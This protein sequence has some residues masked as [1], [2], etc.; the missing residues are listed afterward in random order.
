MKKV[1]AVYFSGTGTTKRTVNFI[2]SN[3][4]EKLCL[5]KE[6]FNFT[7]PKIR[8][9]IKEFDK[10]DFVIFGVPVIA[11][12]VPNVLLKYFEKLKGNG[13]MVVPIVLFGNRNFNDSLLELSDLLINSNFKPISAGAFIGEH[14]FSKILAKGRPDEKDFNIM[15][16]FSEKI[17]EKISKKDFDP[18]KFVE[19]THGERPFK[20]YKP[21]DAEGNYIDIRKVIP[22]T[23]SSLCDDCKV[24][25]AVC[26]MGSIDYND[27]EKITGICIKCCACIKKCH[28][29]A[30]Y[31]ADKGYLYHKKDLE[32]KYKRR[33]EPELFY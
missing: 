2:A 1:Y 17:Y 10:N 22:K 32:E 7:F 24:C 27:T 8:E 14:S 21:K 29:S 11:G 16:E 12:R 15:K 20:Y 9:E 23:I 18:N 28:K 33:A 4:A 31:F 3:L 30:K 6:E 26:P 13:A 25:S 19:I 5:P